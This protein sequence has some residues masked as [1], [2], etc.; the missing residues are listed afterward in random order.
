MG[1]QFDEE[2]EELNLDIGS[3]ISKHPKKYKVSGGTRFANHLIDQVV[4]NVV[5]FGL[6]FGLG[7]NLESTLEVYAISYGVTIV[8]YASLEGLTGQTL[9]KM[10]T[11]S[12]AVN[13]EGERV[14]GNKALGRA[15]CRLIPFDAFSFLGS[16]SRGWHDTISK[17][18]V[19]PKDY[20]E[21]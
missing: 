4:V 10:I 3:K 19:V 13:E 15:L 12:V 14:D 9:G 1:N 11:G 21:R 17:T 16:E 20:L 18:Y 6:I 2:L 5:V 8:Y 7:F